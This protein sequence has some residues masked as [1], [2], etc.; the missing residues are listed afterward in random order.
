MLPSSLLTWFH[1]GP[2]YLRILTYSLLLVTL[3]A[4][5][6]SD[7]VETGEL[8]V[9]DLVT[10]TGDVVEAGMTLIVSYTG[11]LPDGSV[12]DSTSERDRNFM[13]T[14]GVGRVIEGWDTGLLGMR[15]G[16]VRRLIIPSHLAFGRNG[17]CFSD[18]TCAVPAN[19]DVTYEVTL[20]GILDSVRIEDDKIGGGEEAVPGSVLFVQYVGTFQDGTV[21][22]SSDANGG[23]FQ[24]T[25]GA[26]RVIKGWDEGIV[27][28]RVGGVRFL[29]IPPNQAYG[30]FGSSSIPPYAI[31]IFRVELVQVILPPSG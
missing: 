31:L 24:F 8:V 14:V 10:G 26:G 18:G 30:Q 12:F 29:T 17:Q 5:S 11:T 16:G 6:S 4:C 1:P 19:T 3:Q 2:G 25:L 20:V 21:F 13:F 7:A 15:V 23:A 28:M 27:G 22:D 9:Q